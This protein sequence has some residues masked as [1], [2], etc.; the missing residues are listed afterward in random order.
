MILILKLFVKD[1]ERKTINYS[2]LLTFI[3][4]INLYAIAKLIK[5][6][7]ESTTEANKVV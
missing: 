4:I 3:A 2:V 6:S 5:S 7:L 1:Y